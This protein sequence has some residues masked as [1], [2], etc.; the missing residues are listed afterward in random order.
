MSIK[1]DLLSK[2]DFCS[3]CLSLE[4]VSMRNS[5]CLKEAL[6]FLIDN[7]TFGFKNLVLGFVAI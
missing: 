7:N 5:I 6:N 4:T 2:C 3:K 1:K